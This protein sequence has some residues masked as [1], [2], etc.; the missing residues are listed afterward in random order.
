MGSIISIILVTTA[1][2][3]A[4]PHG[5][6]RCAIIKDH[7]DRMTCFAAVTGNASYCAFVKDDTKRAWCYVILG[8]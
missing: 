2:F 3:N 8:K 4:S 7:D 6:A 5:T 1:T